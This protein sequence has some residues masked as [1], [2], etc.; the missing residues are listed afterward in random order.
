MLKFEASLK[1]REKKTIPI[2]LQILSFTLCLVLVNLSAVTWQGPYSSCQ[3]AEE[4]EGGVEELTEDLALNELVD[5]PA[6]LSVI[7]KCGCLSNYSNDHSTQRDFFQI[8][9]PPPELL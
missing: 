2:I 5:S 8:D 1:M 9:S 4:E 3:I 7:E 6:P